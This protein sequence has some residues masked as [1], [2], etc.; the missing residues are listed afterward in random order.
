MKREFPIPVFAV[1]LAGAV[2]AALCQQPWQQ[3]GP[4]GAAVAAMTGVPGYPDDLYFVPEGF[5]AVVWRTTDAG[6]RWTAVETIPA[7][8]TALAVDPLAVRTLYAAG[9]T[10]NVYRSTD[11]GETW[12]VRGT[13]PSGTRVRQLLVNPVTTNELWANADLPGPTGPDGPTSILSV[14]HSTTGGAGWTTSPLDTSFETRAL[15]LAID[16]LHPRRLFAGGSAGNRP[17]LFAS[18]NGGASWSDIAAGLAGTCAYGL[19]VDPLDS[20]ALLCATDA[21]LYRSPDNGANWSRTGAFPAYSVAFAAASPHTA[22]AGSDNLVYRSNN[23]GLSWYADTTS[24]FGTTTR[25]LWVSRESPYELFAANPVGIYYTTNGGFDWT[26]RTAN[27]RSASVTFLGFH[28]PNPETAFATVAGFGPIVSSDHG[29][30]WTRI[31]GFPNSGSAVCIQTNPRHPDTLAVLSAFD[32][33]F[34]LTT[35]RGDSWSSHTTATDFVP[36]GFVYHP[37]DPD[38]LYAWGGKRDSTSGPTRFCL[39]K[40]SDA[41]RHWNT[42][43]LRGPG[44]CHGLLITP[45]LD[46]L[47]AHGAVDNQP[48]L[49]RSTDRGGSWQS[50][51]DGISGSPV[52]ALVRS[53]RQPATIFCATPAG[54]FRSDNGGAYWTNIGLENVTTLLPDTANTSILWAGTDTQGIFYTTN[55]GQV[56]WR[57][58]LSPAPRSILSFQ[59]HPTRPAAVYC[60]TQGR[61]ILGRGIVSVAEP[62]AAPRIAPAL[63]VR[64]SAVRRSATIILP[65]G[66]AETATLDLFTP[67]GRRASTSLSTRLQPQTKWARPAGLPSGTYMLV[68]RRGQEMHVA[69][70]FLTPL[71]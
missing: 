18:E 12:P 45:T 47:F 14:L 69:R 39:L 22:Y 60:A 27:W 66:W 37:S 30:N 53:P 44:F 4:H 2:S 61:S 52:R 65:P 54:V 28:R 17:A 11:A 64:P 67:D 49:L 19:A 10:R 5:P 29:V 43:S 38:T 31:R 25:W 15:L 1:L 35:D 32:S 56:W 6:V 13:L 41:G 40:S 34:W 58:T 8:I 48:A 36:A 23:L 50:L 24:F 26:P 9:W 59:R 51:A 16:P 62:P 20:T 63:Q 71:R 57:D 46:T 68:A 7:I 42:L 33:R 70:L 55:N 3:L 21:G